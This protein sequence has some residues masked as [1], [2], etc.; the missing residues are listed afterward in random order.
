MPLER[1]NIAML[2]ESSGVVRSSENSLKIIVKMLTHM[3]IVVYTWWCWHIC[4]G[5]VIGVDVDQLGEARNVFRC[6]P[7]TRLDLGVEYCFNPL[8]FGS[9]IQLGC[10]VL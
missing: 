1:S 8:C 6:S 3:H 10:V 9:N 2:L 4:K 5:E 7:K